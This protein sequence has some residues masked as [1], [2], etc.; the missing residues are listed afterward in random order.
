MWRSMDKQQAHSIIGRHL[1]KKNFVTFSL[2]LLIGACPF[3]H[4]IPEP[5]MYC[6]M[7]APRYNYIHDNTATIGQKTL[8]TRKFQ[9]TTKMW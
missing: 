4:H 9:L 2:E 5:C 7:S 3:D 8:G 1:G 6:T